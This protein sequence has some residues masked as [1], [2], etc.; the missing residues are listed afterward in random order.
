ML[1]AG[2]GG[3]LAPVWSRGCG[4]RG[5]R[6]G[7]PEF[8][9]VAGAVRV[10]CVSLKLCGGTMVGGGAWADLSASA[11]GTVASRPGLRRAAVPT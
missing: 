9:G 7:V 3:T 1:D 4:L 10:V 8:V 5:L 2:M 6:I 11:A